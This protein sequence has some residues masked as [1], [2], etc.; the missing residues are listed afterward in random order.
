LGSIE[1]T[2]WNLRPRIAG[3]NVLCPKIAR[4]LLRAGRRGGTLVIR[5]AAATVA[6]LVAASAA[7]A[8]K[9]PLAPDAVVPATAPATV[10]AALQFDLGDLDRR[11]AARVSKRLA[12]AAR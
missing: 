10:S 3:L 6:V 9:P 5:I 7:A 8:D 2:A 11:L 12:P 1:G 4:V